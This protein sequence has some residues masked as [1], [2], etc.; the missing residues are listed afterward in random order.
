MHFYSLSLADLALKTTAVVYCT[1]LHL[2]GPGPG[3]RRCAWVRCGSCTSVITLLFTRREAQRQE[4]D[5]AVAPTHHARS[6]R[7]LPRLLFADDTGLGDRL[8]DPGTRGRW[9]EDSSVVVDRTHR[10]EASRVARLTRVHAVVELV[11]VRLPIFTQV[12]W[13]GR[14]CNAQRSV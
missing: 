14:L 4:T 3:W 11:V 12:A 1:V 5:T 8:G 9:T 6:C 2:L 10:S 7:D 13:R